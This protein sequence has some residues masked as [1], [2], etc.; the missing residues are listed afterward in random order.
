[1]AANEW[2]SKGYINLDNDPKG[3]YVL[4]D[5]TAQGE[6]PIL[7]YELHGKLP[8]KGRHWRIKK[9]RAEELSADGR[10]FAPTSGQPKLK[11]Y[12]SES[13]KE[14]SDFLHELT[15]K[16]YDKEI[17][18]IQSVVPR[19]A[20]ILNYDENQTFY[21]YGGRYRADAVLSKSIETKPWVV[22]ELKR[23][24][25]ANPG[26]AIYQ[27][28]RYLDEFGCHT[29]VVL[30]PKSII[31]ISG[32]HQ[33]HYDL[34]SLSD[35]EAEDLLKSMVREAQTETLTEKGISETE[36]VK[37]IEAVEDAKASKEKGETLEKLA[38]YL[39]NATPPLSCKFNNLRT[40][41][42]EIDLVVEY[43]K[44]QKMVPLFEEMGRYCLVECKNWR[45]P[46]GAANVRDFQG[47]LRKCKVR[48]G[49][50]FSKN[51]VTG[52]DSGVDALREIKAMFDAENAYTLVLSLEDIRGITDGNSFIELLDRK[53]YELRFDM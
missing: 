38:A 50:I 43:D 8:P 46:V 49:I 9:E 39:F 28:R 5:L 52:Q 29:G 30:T 48:L 36:L 47:K 20:E 19:I 10:I 7:Q 17:D 21:E 22:L 2:H 51:G 33:K 13:K 42:S 26:D 31:H 53:A 23:K 35:A 27:L 12:L 4:V 45:K 44:T 14:L 24:M 40:R 15:E 25:P 41:S 32:K 11:R 34:Q 16:S 1:M 6:R 37:L 3:P 18:F